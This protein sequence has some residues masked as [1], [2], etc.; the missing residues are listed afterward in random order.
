MEMPVKYS[1]ASVLAF[2]VGMVTGM[3]IGFVLW[4][5]ADTFGVFPAFIGVGPVL[6]MVLQAAADRRNDD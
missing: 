3:A 4:I 1:P 2:A 6:G 5:A